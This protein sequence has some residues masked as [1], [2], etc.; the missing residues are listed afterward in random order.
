VVSD[1][2]L[3]VH[4]PTRE[5]VLAHQTVN[6]TVMRKHTVIPMSFGTVFK[7]KDD[8][9]ELLKSAFDAFSD[10]LNKMQN[11]VE[12]GSGPLGSRGG[13]ARHREGGRGHPEAQ[14]RDRRT[15]GLDL[16]RAHAVR[17]P[18]RRDLQ[19]RSE[20][21]LQEIFGALRDVSVRAAP[22]SRSATR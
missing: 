20:R 5:N 17:P 21:Y 6:E 8:I 3:T 12:F 1:T 4:D 19:A 13:G 7:T 10:V 14:E 9:V 22:T 2:P 11:K 15:E 18:R 16:L